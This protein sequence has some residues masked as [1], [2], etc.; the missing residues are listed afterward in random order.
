MQIK[1]G[2]YSAKLTGE[3]TKAVLIQALKLTRWGLRAKKVELRT[4]VP[5][6]LPNG[7]IIRLLYNGAAV[8]QCFEGVERQDFLEILTL[9]RETAAEFNAERQ[10]AEQAR[11]QLNKRRPDCWI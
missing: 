6:V 2:P 3:D 7:V 10:R 5:A 1:E 9:I 8:I 4:G 11:E